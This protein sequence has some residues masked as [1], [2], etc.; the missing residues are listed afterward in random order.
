M[1]LAQKCRGAIRGE[2]F[3]A[4]YGGEEFTI[5]LERIESVNTVVDVVQK[6]IDSLKEPREVGGRSIYVT[7]SI[8]IAL[9]P[10]DAMDPMSLLKNADAAMY[11]AKNE[12]RNNYQFYTSDMTERAFER[13]M[14][15]TRIRGSLPA[16][17]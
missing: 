4:R 5:I 3:L 11:K 2:D 14:L 16:S 17:V 13:I 7:F 8:G 9:Y 10:H 6:L 1:A 12:G 15:E